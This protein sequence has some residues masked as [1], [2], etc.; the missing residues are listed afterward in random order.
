MHPRLNILNIM[1]KCTLYYCK[2]LLCS[3]FILNMDFIMVLQDKFFK[4]WHLGLLLSPSLE[5]LTLNRNIHRSNIRSEWLLYSAPKCLLYIALFGI[6]FVFRSVQQK[7]HTFRIGVK[8]WVDNKR[9]VVD[10]EV[11][12][13]RFWWSP[14]YIVVL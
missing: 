1:N 8:I 10:V 7:L 11:T 5:S 12:K 2:K 13:K 9:M 3:A 4:S 14:R 6:C